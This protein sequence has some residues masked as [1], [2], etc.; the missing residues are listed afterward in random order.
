[1]SAKA[2]TLWGQPGYVW[3]WLA[4]FLV[5]LGGAY[6]LYTAAIQFIIPWHPIWV[7]LVGVVLGLA[8]SVLRGS[9]VRKLAREAAA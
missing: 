9:Q 2:D 3:D 1:M 8:L 4:G 6:L 7:S 5:G